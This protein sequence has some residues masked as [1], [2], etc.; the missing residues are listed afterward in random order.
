M[1][2][3]QVSK[4]RIMEDELMNLMQRSPTFGLIGDKPDKASPALGSSALAS[5]HHHNHHHHAASQRQAYAE[6]EAR[7]SSLSSSWSQ[8]C[9]LT[10]AKSSECLDGEQ[11][12]S[13][14]VESSYNT[15]FARYHLETYRQ[16]DRLRW[17]FDFDHNRPL[18]E[19]H[20]H[21]HQA[22]ARYQWQPI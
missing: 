11:C 3:V 8:S 22:V 18:D 13:K 2:N 16:N 7:S 6:P 4:Y 10:G 14:E 15:K 19:N 12:N 9:S 1:S 17:N 20:H 5:S 21:H